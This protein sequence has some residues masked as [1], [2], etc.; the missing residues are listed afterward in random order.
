MSTISEV[1][2]RDWDKIDIEGARDILK[3]DG[4]VERGY[5][6]FEHFVNQVELL[7]QQQIEASKKQVA[8][9]FRPKE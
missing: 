4:R 2:I 6:F 8:A 7:K 1:D 5:A 3:R 9:L